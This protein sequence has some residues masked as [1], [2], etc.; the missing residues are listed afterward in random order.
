MIF[1]SGSIV[2]ARR[3]MIMR[4]IRSLTLCL[5]LLPAVAF[6]GVRANA[7][8]AG[9][10]AGPP[11]IPLCYDV[12][13]RP[14]PIYVAGGDI[15]LLAALAKQLAL[16]STQVTIVQQAQRSC[17]ALQLLNTSTSLNNGP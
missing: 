3:V 8:D 10:D 15:P 4:P 7:A 13:D 11:P 1:C 2:R 9:A 5:G 17:T 16:D 14:N 12:V 6:L